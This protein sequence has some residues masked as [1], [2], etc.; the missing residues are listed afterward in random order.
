MYPNLWR[1]LSLESAEGMIDLFWMWLDHKC[2]NLLLDVLPVLHLLIDDMPIEV[3]LSV[4]P[5]YPHSGLSILGH[6]Q[7]RLSAKIL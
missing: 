1:V 4:W 5:S 7:L 3:F 6:G 2:N